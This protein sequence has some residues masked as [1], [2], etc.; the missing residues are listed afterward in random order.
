[1]FFHVALAA[2]PWDFPDF[3]SVAF[4]VVGC[5]IPAAFVGLG[6]YLLCVRRTLYKLKALVKMTLLW[7]GACWVGALSNITFEVRRLTIRELRQQPGAI[8]T[9]ISL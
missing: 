7:R 2:D 8:P 5:F 9:L 6:L 1:M 4:A 3:E